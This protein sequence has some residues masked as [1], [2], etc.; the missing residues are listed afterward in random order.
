MKTG[1]C[2]AINTD[3]NSMKKVVSIPS[4]YTKDV[5]IITKDEFDVVY[6]NLLQGI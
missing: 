3:K 1:E 6:K 4:A 2:I 5:A